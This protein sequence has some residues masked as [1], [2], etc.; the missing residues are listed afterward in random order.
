MS[1]TYERLKAALDGATDVDLPLLRGLVGDLELGIETRDEE[2]KE[3]MAELEGCRKM[4]TRYTLLVR[5]MQKTLG[6]IER[7]CKDA[8]WNGSNHVPVDHIRA[9]MKIAPD[10][11]DYLADPAYR[12]NRSLTHD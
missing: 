11:R 3:T 5:E 2:L 7:V 1:G 9:V 4:G 12:K 10:E 6:E 8:M